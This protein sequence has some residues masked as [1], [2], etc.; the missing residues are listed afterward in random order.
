M[1]VR[2]TAEGRAKICPALTELIANTVSAQRAPKI[3]SRERKH[4]SEPAG[5]TQGTWDTDSS[6]VR[7][8]NWHSSVPA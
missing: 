1:V 8:M 2:Q 3:D 4:P 5:Q 7:E 6:S